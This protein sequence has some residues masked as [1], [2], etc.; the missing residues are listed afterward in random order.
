MSE[1]VQWCE[2]HASPM[3]DK[4]RCV[5]VVKPG[6][7]GGACRDTIRWLIPKETRSQ[8]GMPPNE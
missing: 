2:Q 8:T 3:F 1:R 4:K 6:T 5:R 7:S